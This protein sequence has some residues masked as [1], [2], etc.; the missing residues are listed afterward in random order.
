MV[1]L[2]R[3]RITSPFLFIIARESGERILKNWPFEISETTAKPT[4][5]VRH[6]ASLWS[7]ID[8]NG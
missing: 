6:Y 2:S 5:T 1:F 7:L 4:Y 3:G 8:V